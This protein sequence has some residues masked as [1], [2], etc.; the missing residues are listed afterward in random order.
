MVVTDSSSVKAVSDAFINGSNP[1]DIDMAI[2]ELAGCS[3]GLSILE[4]QLPRAGP[5]PVVL[6][7]RQ[8]H[9]GVVLCYHMLKSCKWC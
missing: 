9:P 2:P 3:Y 4:I 7:P 5:D 1:V 8:L 6:H